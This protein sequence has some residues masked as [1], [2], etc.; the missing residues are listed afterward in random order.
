MSAQLNE[1]R[2]QLERLDYESKE[3]VITVDILREQN[4]D[5]T[6][7]LEELKKTILEL[8]SIQKD[9]SVEDKEKKKAEKMALMMAQFDT[10]RYKQFCIESWAYSFK[11]FCSRASSLRKRK[12]S[13]PP[14]PSLML[15]TRMRALAP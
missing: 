12:R 5:L 8:R 14:S 10:V 4:Q 9:S 11:C 7:E 13:V 2:M 6:N 15:L 1:L 3:G